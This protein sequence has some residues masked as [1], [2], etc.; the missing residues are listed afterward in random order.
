MTE[1]GETF[2]ILDRHCSQ[3]PKSIF[4]VLI[5]RKSCQICLI[6]WQAGQEGFYSFLQSRLI[7]RYL[8][9][10]PDLPTAHQSTTTVI[11]DTKVFKYK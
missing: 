9:K 3:Q 8:G 1:T 10:P 2:P 7:V 6:M 4:A 5:N 11:V